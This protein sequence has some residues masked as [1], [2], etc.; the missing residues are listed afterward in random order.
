MRKDDD[1]SRRRRESGERRRR[2]SEEKRRRSE[3]RRRNSQDRRRKESEDRRRRGSEGR[4][5]NSRDHHLDDE[6]KSF[7][8]RRQS[9]EERVT[10]R[11]VF[12]QEGKRDR[13]T[14]VRINLSGLTP[15]RRYGIAVNENG[16]TRR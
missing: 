14:N 4:R 1:E 15:F 13:D 5:R 3:E 11:I 6:D 9:P 8:K 10:G 12:I 2:E 7:G 16:N